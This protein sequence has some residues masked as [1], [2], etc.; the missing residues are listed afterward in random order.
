MIF[1]VLSAFYFS[2]FCSFVNDVSSLY[3]FASNI[4][5]SKIYEEIYSY[6]DYN[7]AIAR[8]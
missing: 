1:S 7:L 4:L 2:R 6:M 3:T 8:D 5:I